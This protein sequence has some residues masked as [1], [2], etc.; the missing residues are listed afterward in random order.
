VLPDPEG[1]SEGGK[2]EEDWK[3][4]IRYVEAPCKLFV[5]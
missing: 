5:Q 2:L 3:K 1:R 4:K